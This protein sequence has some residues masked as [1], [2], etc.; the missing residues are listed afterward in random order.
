MSNK[1]VTTVEPIVE[2]VQISVK[3]QNFKL[4]KIC[5]GGGVG[6]SCKMKIKN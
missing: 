4:I 2:D 3:I 5:G 1:K 6:K